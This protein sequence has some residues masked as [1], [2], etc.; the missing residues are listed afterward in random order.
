MGAD[1]HPEDRDV[2]GEIVKMFEAEA[3]RAE[4][5]RRAACLMSEAI[6]RAVSRILGSLNVVNLQEWR[7]RRSLR[8]PR[9]E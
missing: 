9:P 7:E 1:M 8:R 6:E 4:T 3:T 2:A 5:E